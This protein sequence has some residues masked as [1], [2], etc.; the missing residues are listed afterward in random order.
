MIPLRHQILEFLINEQSASNRFV[1][2]SKEQVIRFTDGLNASVS[3][4]LRSMKKEGLVKYEVID[5]KKGVYQLKNLQPRQRPPQL[6]EFWKKELYK[7][8]EN[9]ASNTY[10]ASRMIHDALRNI[11]ETSSKSEVLQ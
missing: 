6:V 5:N 2:I 10:Q 4:Q 8:Q 3:R 9:K 7:L 11:S 1:I